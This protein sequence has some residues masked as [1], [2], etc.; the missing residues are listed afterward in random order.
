[1]ASLINTVSHATRHP[2]Y[3]RIPGLPHDPDE[4]FPGRAG[5]LSRPRCEA[6]DFP[7]SRIATEAMSTP[8]HAV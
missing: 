3:V 5:L 7:T 8:A 1:M 4:R 6:G 2:R